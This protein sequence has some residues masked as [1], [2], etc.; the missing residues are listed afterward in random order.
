MFLF[1]NQIVKVSKMRESPVGKVYIDLHFLA[2]EEL[3][4]TFNFSHD[5]LRI[6]F[7]VLIKKHFSR[8]SYRAVDKNIF[9][10]VGM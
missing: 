6:N 3:H 9:L 4:L 8:P 1:P 7:L 10:N 5:R 2:L